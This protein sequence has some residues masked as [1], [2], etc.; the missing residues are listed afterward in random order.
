MDQRRVV[1]G[2]GMS[3]QGRVY[4]PITEDYQ[5]GEHVVHNPS[6]MGRI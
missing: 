4:Q 5:S 2:R 3:R 1:C 6:L